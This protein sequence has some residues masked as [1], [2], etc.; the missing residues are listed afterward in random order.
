MNAIKYLDKIEGPQDLKKLSESAL[1][2]LADEVRWT[3]IETVSKTGGH[4][5]PSLGVVELAVAI[6][7]VFDAPKDKIVWDVGHQAYAHKILTGRY[8]RFDTLRQDGGLSGFVRMSESPYDAF[9]VGHSSTSISA[10]L[11]MA[12]AKSLS[13]DPA[14]VVAII[15]DGSMTAGMAYEA[16]NQAGGL[17]KDLIVV[18]NDNEMSIAP[19][20]GALSS[21]VSRKLSSSRRFLGLRNEFKRFLKP[22]SMRYGLMKRVEESLKTFLT[23]GM[24]FEAFDFQYLGPIPGHRL[25]HL[26]EALE[27]AKTVNAPALVHVITKKGKGYPPAEA[28]PTYFHGVGS[29]EISTGACASSDKTR[30]TYT[31]AFGDTL[32]RLAE[33]NEKIVAVTAAMPEGTGLAPFARAYPLRFFDVGIAEQHG[34][35]FAAGLAA[36]GYRPVVAIY[37]TFI[38]RAF[39]Q[40]LHDVCI[41]R[42]PVLFALDRAGLVGEDGPTHHGA[43][44]LSFLRSIPNL[45][46][47]APRDEAEL[48]RMLA[49]GLALNGPSAIRYPRGVGVGTPLPDNPEPIPIG[50]AE[51]LRRGGHCVILAVGR[52]VCEAM[53]AATELALGGIETTVVDA[54][55]IKPLDEALILELCREIPRL[56]TVEENALCGGFG[57]AVL[58]C[59]ADN[60]LGG[61]R[62]S[63]IG[64]MDQFVEHGPQPVLRRR[65]GLDAAGIAHA[66]RQVV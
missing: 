23:P 7:R 9:T 58:E 47:M 15:G 18:L 44:D 38:Q 48:A 42:L 36:E 29:F 2:D 39:D 22:G 63:R 20:V 59:L 64:I 43:F 31:Q 5:A 37:S 53:S 41:E 25:D 8:D 12:C 51:I 32:L 57:G 40:V 55:F 27:T 62:V 54:R 61:V 17:H 46:L 1:A 50:Q 52:M 45:V 60:G 13:H 33:K 14:K 4:L 3:I 21:F 49:T 26:I 11:G 28:N 30:L 6:H 34:V 35:T 56:V 16:L 66:V 65:Y 19:N 10:A 24:L